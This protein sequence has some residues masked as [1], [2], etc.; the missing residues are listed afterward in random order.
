MASITTRTGV[1]GRTYRVAWR[2]AGE[3]YGESFKTN[4]DARDF[5]AWVELNPSGTLSRWQAERRTRAEVRAEAG[6]TVAELYAEYTALRPAS[7]SASRLAADDSL[8]RMQLA[9]LHG[10]HV[11]QDGDKVTPSVKAVRT[12]QA[13]L[14]RMPRAG[15]IGYAPKTI[16]DARGLLRAVMQVAVDDGVIRVNPVDSVRAPNAELQALTAEDVLSLAELEAVLK[17]APQRWRALFTVMGYT[18]CRLSEALGLTPRH[19]DLDA[20]TMAIRQRVQEVAGKSTVAPGAKTRGSVRETWL[21]PEVI[22]ALRDHL[23]AYPAGEDELIFRTESGGIPSRSNLLPRQ[24]APALLAAGVARRLGVMNLRHTAISHML[25]AGMPAIAVAA[26]VGHANPT[27]TLN[28]YA[29]FIPHPG[30]TNPDA[31]RMA[32]WRRELGR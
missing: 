2:Y 10:V 13:G 21:D 24:F 31:A 19:I 12:W 27:M 30:E 18:G 5:R 16:A 17:C 1:R 9:G 23:A 6:P 11:R 7:V 3:Q 29:R 26:R 32:T 20:G 8:F 22:D 28:R 14:E 15:R 4:D 25:G